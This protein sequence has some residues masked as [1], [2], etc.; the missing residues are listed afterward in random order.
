MSKTWQLQ[1]A[2]N[3]FS[4]VVEKA[5]RKGPQ[6]ITRRGDKVAVLV[7][8]GDYQKLTAKQEGLGT[9][10]MNSPLVGSELEIERSDEAV[11]QRVK[12]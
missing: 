10:L 2:K 8:F 3:Q 11:P 1:D 9:F 4:A 12:L 6:V 7:S 5:M